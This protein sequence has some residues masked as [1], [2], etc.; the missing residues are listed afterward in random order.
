MPSGL[1]SAAEKL[2]CD[3][4]ERWEMDDSAALTHLANA[5]RSLT[6][7]KQLEAILAKEGSII[8]NRFRQPAR[9]PAHAVMVS[10]GRNFRQCME[11]L[12]LDIE[13]LYQLEEG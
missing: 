2:W 13:S 6:R 12:K 8:Q 11:A 5:C 1:C 10:E 9:H 7:L 4:V 3:T